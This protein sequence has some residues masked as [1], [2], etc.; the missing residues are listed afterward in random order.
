MSDLL[1]PHAELRRAAFGDLE[2]MRNLAGMSAS[3]FEQ[4][5]CPLTLLEGLPFAR[6]AAMHGHEYDSFAL[7]NLLGLAAR[8]FAEKGDAETAEYLSA[9]A[10]AHLSRMAD[11]GSNEATDTLADFVSICSPREAE[12]GRAIYRLMMEKGALA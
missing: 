5:G 11:Q 8:A 10:V 3:S 7:F 6:M 12:W 1:N 9:E 2:A 4:D